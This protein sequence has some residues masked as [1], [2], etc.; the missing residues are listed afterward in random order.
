MRALDTM[1][2][3]PTTFTIEY[4]ELNS[5][6]RSAIAAYPETVAIAPTVPIRLIEPVNFSSISAAPPLAPA[7][8]GISWGVKAV[9]ADTS[10]FTG[11]GI[12]VAVL[13]TGINPDH[14]AF[15]GVTLVQKNFT[16]STNPDDENGHGTHCA[17]TIFGRDVDDL[18]IGVA[19]GISKALIGKVLGPGGGNSQQ[20]VQAIQWAVSEG[21]NV[22]S[23]SLGIDFPGLVAAW[24][25]HGAPPELATSKALVAFRE[26]VQLFDSLSEL[27]RKIEPIGTTSL[28]VAASGNESRRNQNPDF[29]IAAGPPAAAEGFIAVGALQQT[30][31]GLNVAPFSNSGAILSGPGVDIISAHFKGGLASLSGTSMA[32]PH[33][34]G[35]AALWA[36]KLRKSHLLTYKN[37][38]ARL[39]A[40]GTTDPLK[41]GFDPDEVGAGIVQA[42]QR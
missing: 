30:P 32:T 29:E 26:T 4:D 18:R 9:G 42:P 40:S 41:P 35:V 21:A 27:I 39:I 11:D 1:R 5:R 15:Q 8:P 7:S 34:A 19:P 33:V 38:Q 16:E 10:P 17:G 37:F 2:S 14:P 23:M 28:L 25:R 3:I 6:A 12:V 36:E 22:I 20:L 24:I 13:D 31:A